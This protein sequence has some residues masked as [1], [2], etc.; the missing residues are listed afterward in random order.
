MKK[1]YKWIILFKYNWLSPHFIL[2]LHM[3]PC[4]YIKK[5]IATPATTIIKSHSHTQYPNFT[6]DESARA[7]RR[8]VELPIKEVGP[9]KQTRSVGPS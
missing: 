3:I 2:F 8:R 4:H 1:Y 9:G 6:G 5:E 7:D